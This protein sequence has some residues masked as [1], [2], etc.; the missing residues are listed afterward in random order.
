MIEHLNKDG[1]IWWQ[2][3]VVDR[4]DPF[5]IGRCKVRI[6]GYHGEK[7]DIPDD[8]LPWAYP[9]MPINVRPNSVA[10]GLVEGVWV[11]GF[12]RDGN[13]AQEPVI[14]H[15]INYGKQKDGD[16]QVRSENTG[17][18]PTGGM[19]TNRLAQGD[20][21][22]TVID[23]IHNE[24]DDLLIGKPKEKDEIVAP[25]SPYAAQFPHNY[26][27]ESESGHVIQIDD[28]ENAERLSVTHRAGTFIEVHPDGTQVAK[29]VGDRFTIIL[30]DDSIRIDGDYNLVING[31]FHTN[32]KKRVDDIGGDKLD[33]I[34]GN[35][36][37][38]IGGNK[39]VISTDGD[40]SLESEKHNINITSS[41]NT[42]VKGSQVKIDGQI[43]LN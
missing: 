42:N 35:H 18:H 27:E 37:E 5:K 7:E 11:L 43:F 33:I 8:D 32:M 31:E 1:F 14:T 24:N 19:N 10:T 2:G 16:F 21:E 36:D 39:K 9:A 13:N 4:N 3:V 15:L 12:F 20:S 22:D 23:N 26:V 29:I 25:I 40:V 30:G 28:T 41:G 6:L 17:A 34:G 38:E